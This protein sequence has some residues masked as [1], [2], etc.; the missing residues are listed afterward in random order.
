MTQSSIPPH[1]SP[2]SA[3]K[4]AAERLQRALHALEQNLAPLVARV[5]ELEDAA[6]DNKNFET[7]RARLATALD[8]A[9]A[10]ELEYKA[11][12]ADVSQLADETAKEL[13]GV[14]SQVLGALGEG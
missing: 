2:P 8:A 14:I 5:S 12:E 10:R 4:E 13:E 9:K 6:A 7:D 3:T 11:R 1:A